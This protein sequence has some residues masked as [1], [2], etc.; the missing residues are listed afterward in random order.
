MVAGPLF[1]AVALGEVLT[2]K[3]FDLRRHPLS[4]LSVGSWGW[5]QIANFVVAG[6]LAVGLALAVRR[7][8]HHGRAG[9]LGPLLIGL[10]GVGLIAGGVFVA[11]PALGFPPGTPD[12]VPTE[13]SWH[14]AIHNFAPMVAFMAVILASFVLVWRFIGLR[15]P[16]WAAYSGVTGAVALGFSSWPTQDGISWRLAVAIVVIFVWQTTYAAKLRRELAA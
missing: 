15:Q 2:R 14:A 13:F 6:V 11:D 8:V 12:G 16:G 5:I 1:M 4:L 7:V 9:I 10:Y 3:G